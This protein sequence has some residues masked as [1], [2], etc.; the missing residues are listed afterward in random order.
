M[1]AIL[2]LLV[3]TLFS[4]VHTVQG[5]AFQNTPGLTVSSPKDGQTV[6]QDQPLPLAAQFAARRLIGKNDKLAK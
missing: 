3:V 1:K 4:L 2:V 6:A 5:Q